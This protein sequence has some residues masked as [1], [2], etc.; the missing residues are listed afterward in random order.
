MIETYDFLSRVIDAITEHIVVIDTQGAIV[1][2]NRS[3][4]AFA[5]QNNCLIVG[6][7]WRQVNYL[8][9]CDESA[10]R[11]DEFGHLAAIGI[12]H[13]I[14][15]TR[16]LF[17]LEYPC[18]SPQVKRWFMMRVTPFTAGATSYFVVSHQNITERKLAEEQVLNTSRLDGLTG[19]A[20]RRYLDEFLEQEGKR[21]ARLKL[22]I[23]L[24][25][26][27]IDHFKLL[28]DTY[29][30]LT[31]DECLKSLAM[32]LQRFTNR[33]GDLCARYGG[34]E[35]AVVYGNTTGQ[36]ARYLADQII[37]AI[38]EL[39]IPNEA[40][41]TLPIMTAS[42][43]VATA[44]PDARFQQKTLIETADQRLYLAKHQG[45]N[46]VSGEEDAVPIGS[47]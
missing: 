4:D 9:V 28:N 6:D 46:Q 20:N 16:D 39:N 43:G 23:S 27:D 35:F 17:Y 11:G 19:I 13:V 7:D 12:R 41:P 5:R 29:G 38:R 34:E 22:P 40:S 10:M 18:H 45:R 2:A 31:G 32:V 37:E 36:Q 21:C 1:Y 47:A 26:I 25:I 14:S 30:H 8:T 33:P 3:W 44:Y 42:I 24:V 15:G